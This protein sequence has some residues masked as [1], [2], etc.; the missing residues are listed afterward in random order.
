MPNLKDLILIEDKKFDSKASGKRLREILRILHKHKIT[1]KLTPNQMVE[2]LEDLGPTFIKIGQIMSNRS[3]TLPLEYCTALSKLRTKVPPM[4]F[5]QV[6]ACIVESYGYDPKQVFASLD[7]TPLGSASIAQVH[8]G[9]LHDGSIVAVKV[10]RPGIAKEMAS[11]LALMHRAVRILAAT[12]PRRQEELMSSLEGFVDEL[13]RTTSDEL[14][15][16]VELSNLERFAEV[17]KDHEGVSSPTP[18]GRYS[19]SEVLVMEFVDGVMMEDVD[20]IKEMGVDLNELGERVTKSYLD[21]ML[22]AGFFHADPHPGNITLRM[23]GGS[24]TTDVKGVEATIQTEN[25]AVAA[26][27]QKAVTRVN[28]ADAE[29]VWIDLGMV[30]KLSESEKVLVNDM[31]TALALKDSYSLKNSIL[32]LTSGANTLDIDHGRMLTQIDHLLAKYMS[33]DVGNMDI[34]GAFNDIIKI[35]QDNKLKVPSSL[36]MLGRGMIT[37]QGFIAE[38]SPEVNLVDILTEY[39]RKHMMTPDAV[40]EM[41]GDAVMGTASAAKAAASIPVKAANLLD[42]AE[43]GNLR[44]G[45]NMRFTQEFRAAIYSMGGLICLAIISMGLFLGSSILC[46][47]QATVWVLSV[48]Y[49]GLGGFVGAAVLSIYVIIRIF[50][51]RSQQHKNREFD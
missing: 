15:F 29:V 45:L 2:L 33:A 5:E 7:E 19:T 35:M 17:I 13:S 44:M 43:H 28:P 26:G 48:Y 9:V 34:G 39:V 4:T 37:L 12:A 47:S 27:A 1:K 49:I 6:K 18:Y 16:K 8:K 14:D 3:D 36:T 50:R 30:G 42:M 51:L 20:K 41:L 31:I 11:D 46:L 40:K 22:S 38:I 23:K 10:R 21:Q 24:V 32:S 25:H